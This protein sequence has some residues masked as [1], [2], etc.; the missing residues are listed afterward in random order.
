MDM[1]TNTDSVQRE[2]YTCVIMTVTEPE[3]TTEL[4][5]QLRLHN[6]ILD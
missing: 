2:K 6:D 4:G 1:W 3:D 5:T